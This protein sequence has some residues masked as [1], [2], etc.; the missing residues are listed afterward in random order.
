MN[1]LKRCKIK[2]YADGA[3][4]KSIRKFSKNKIISGLTTNPS[5]IRK[6]GEKNYLNFAKKLATIEKKKPISLEIFANK[7]KEIIRQAKIL[8]KLGNNVYVKI[9]IIN[10]KGLF[11]GEVI[12]K[13]QQENIRLNITA[14]FTKNQILDLKKIIENKDIILS[15]FCGRIADTGKNPEIITKFTKKLFSKKKKIKIL[16]AS[17]RE[18]YNIFQAENSGADIITIPY[19]ILDKLKLLNFN[20]NKYSLQTVREFTQDAKK[21]RFKI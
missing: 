10:D 6:S 1:L 18:V 12:K 14:I 2:L 19:N 13:L 11:L 21:S 16:W 15:I 17:T 9:P 4:I 20:L 5:L 8:S 7:P 3:D